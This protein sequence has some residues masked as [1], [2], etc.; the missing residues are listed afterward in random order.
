MS[1]APIR[2]PVASGFSVASA[3]S[4]CSLLLSLARFLRSSLRGFGYPEPI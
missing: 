3:V 4:W 2:G 1:L